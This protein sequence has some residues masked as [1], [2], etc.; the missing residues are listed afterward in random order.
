MSK[1]KKP[2]HQ[3]KALPQWYEEAGR[4]GFLEEKPAKKPSA[5]ES[6]N[7]LD[8]GAMGQLAAFKRNLEEQTAKNKQ[9]AATAAKAKAKEAE[10]NT[11]W[12]ELAEKQG[13][14]NSDK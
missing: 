6:V 5:A 2:Q 12:F 13:Y 4:Q 1:K 9:A 8:E 10:K 11:H 7:R 14:L 3:S